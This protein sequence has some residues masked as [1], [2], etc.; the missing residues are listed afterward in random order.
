MVLAQKAAKEILDGL[1]N[2][3]FGNNRTEPISLIIQQPI[4][5]WAE[6]F[7]EK[8]L[9]GDAEHKKWLTDAVRNHLTGKPVP[10]CK[11][12]VNKA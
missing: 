10:D 4:N 9:H 6:S 2:R 12:L 8:A 1:V 11:C 5:E 7:L 3:K